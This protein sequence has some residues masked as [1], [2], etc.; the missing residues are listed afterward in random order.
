MGGGV[1]DGP[2]NVCFVVVEWNGR[3][4][5]GGECKIEIVGLALRTIVS[6]HL[7]QAPWM[8]MRGGGESN[9]KLSAPANPSN[10]AA[11]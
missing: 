8:L 1:W 7:P 5:F 9:L 3:G 11:S 6:G 4:I 2:P 10:E